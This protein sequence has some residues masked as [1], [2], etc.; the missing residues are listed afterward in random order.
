[1]WR[2][3]ILKN[4]LHEA[5]FW[6]HLSVTNRPNHE[7][8]AKFVLSALDNPYVTELGTFGGSVRELCPP[9]PSF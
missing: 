4:F 7:T 3:F 9:S 6:G 5:F 1:M 8:D 2:L